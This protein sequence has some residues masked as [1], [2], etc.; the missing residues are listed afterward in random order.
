MRKITLVERHVLDADD[1]LV[2]LELGNPVD[3][4][5]RVAVRQNPLD[6]RVVQRKGQGLHNGPKYSRKSPLAGRRP[7]ATG[8]RLTP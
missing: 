4:Q 6:R 1:P 5:E 8:I 7:N 2:Q 3:Q